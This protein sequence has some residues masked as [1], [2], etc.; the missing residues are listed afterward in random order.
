MNEQLRSVALLQ[1]DNESSAVVVIRQEIEKEYQTLIQNINRSHLSALSH[2]LPL[3]VSADSLN[4]ES[5][6][7][8]QTLTKTIESLKAQ[9]NQLSSLLQEDEQQTSHL[10]TQ[11]KELDLMKR[12]LQNAVERA[13]TAERRKRELA[14]ELLAQRTK[15][16]LTIRDLEGKVN[17]YEV[18]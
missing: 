1:R 8:V 18:T 12:E 13:S 10:R 7:K 4:S 15:N 16:E 11:A 9:C 5:D 14:S 2:T 6:S 3:C 17:H